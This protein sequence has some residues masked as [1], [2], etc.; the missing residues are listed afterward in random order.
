M[1]LRKLLVITILL[2][3]PSVTN[4]G[5]VSLLVIDA[6]TYLVNKA[7]KGLELPE[8]I[9][10][11]YFTH[12]DLTRDKQA[13]DFVDKSEVIIVDVMMQELSEYLIQHIR[14]EGKKIYA[15]RGTRDDDALK[16]KG[17]IFD[18]DIKEYYSHLIPKNIRNLV[19]KLIHRELNAPVHYDDVIKLPELR[20]YHPDADEIFTSYE[21]YEKWYDQSGHKKNAPRIGVMCFGSSLIEGQMAHISYL[22]QRLETAGFNVLPAFGKDITVLR[23]IIADENRNARADLILAFTLKFYSTIDDELKSLINDLNIPIIN[24]VNLYSSTIEEWRKDPVGIPPMDVMWNIANSEISG[25]IEPTPLSGKKKIFDKASGR[26]FFIHLPIKE[27]I[28]LLIPRIRKWVALKQKENK[29]KQIA[30]LYYNHSQGKQ[31]IGASYLNVFRSLELILNRMKQ[32]GY[33][34]TLDERIT[35]DGIKDLVLKYGRNIGS[36]SPG[37]LDKML[38]EE[39]VVRVPVSTYKT[40]FE[41]LPEEFKA[42]VIRQWGKV[43]DSKM[44]IKDGSFVMPAVMLGNVVILPEPS[45][46]WGDDP[47]KLYHDP[48]VYP[49]HQYIAAYLW[50]KYEFNADAMIHLGTHAT[51]EWLPGKQAG[52][53]DSCPPE[54]LITDIPNLY[55]YIVD[56]VGE[57][58]QAKRRGR[59]VII[60]HLTPPLKE[61]GL[62]HEYAELYD[63]ISSYNRSVSVKS[64]TSEAKLEKIK[65]KAVKMGIDKDLEIK[66]FD[67][68]GIEEIEHYLLEVKTN[69]MPYGMHTF[70]KSFDGDALEDMVKCVLKRNDDVN[71]DDLRKGFAASGPREINHLIKGLNGGY[72]PSGEGNDPVRNPSAIPTGKNFFGFDPDKIPSKVAWELGKKAAEDIIEKH[73]KEK[74][75]YPE[76][77]AVVVWATETIRNEGINE[78]TILYL[79]GMK[80]VWDKS[81]RVKRVEVIPGRELK[82]PRI[83]VLINPSGLYRDLFPNML[84]FLD[85]AVQKA[86]VQEDIENLIRKHTEEMRSHLIASGM[87]EKEADLFSKIRIFTEKPGTYGTGVS[88]MTSASGVWESDEEIVKVYENRVGFAFGLGKWGEPAQEVF[89]NNLKHVNT[90]IHSVSSNVYG[91][92]DNDDVFQYLGGLSLAVKKE[93]GETPDTLISMQ[94]DPEKAEIE[95]VAKT[96]GRELRSRYFNPKWIEGMKKEKYAGAREIEKFVEYMWGW[97]VTVPYAVDKTKWEQTYEVYVE[98]KYGLDIK[99]FFN[100]ENPWAYQS[101]TARMLETVRKKYWQADEKVTQKL[102]VEYA[103]NVVEK[104]VACCDHTCNNPVLNQMVVNIIS[105][106]GV[107]SPEMVEKFRMAIEQ[108]AQKSLEEQVRARKELQ[109]QLNEGFDKNKKFSQNKESSKKADS[110]KQEAASASEADSKNVEGYKMEDMQQKDDTTDMSSSGVQWFA[111]VFVFLI[112]GLF[113]YG[114]KR[115]R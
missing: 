109:K 52:L 47:M 62:Y 96:I 63:L 1:N 61:S 76:K 81:G 28:E 97:Q 72:I 92:M 58:I 39:K 91:T 19:Y 103:L 45:R 7:V 105:L 75:T 30:I 95:D 60:D 104:G 13:N 35:E 65:Q 84:L 111:S 87:D 8:N 71:P 26:D 90:A 10:V 5:S 74:K 4:A 32:E 40:W 16:A 59:G 77:V 108:A 36:W 12:E 99:E 20:L 110:E 57:G 68:E 83:D 69:F 64:E 17:F 21:A 29:E 66:V 38:S 102:A 2:L 33:A 82:R 43:E 114:M 14:F 113:V 115:F 31:N 42:N 25:I 86:A 44:M 23:K 94:R 80:P 50:L 22:I 24:A 101:V 18:L 49:H 78:S 106:P 11:K 46:G 88:E 93:S 51:H 3:I 73:L 107:M 34:V 48:T 79:M 85:D 100:K 41:K 9:Q 53:S 98:D 89:K 27:N 56:D 112:L 55:P 6:N 15:V 70:G 54:V 67:E 37:E